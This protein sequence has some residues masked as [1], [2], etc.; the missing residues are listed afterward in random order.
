MHELFHWK[1]A[2][3]FKSQLGRN[4]FDIGEYNRVQRRKA[5][6]ALIDKGIDTINL[7]NLNKISRYAYSSS[8]DNDWEEVYTEYRTMMVLRGEIR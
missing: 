4:P 7:W 1:D 2:S 3:E 8:L 5:R 6:A